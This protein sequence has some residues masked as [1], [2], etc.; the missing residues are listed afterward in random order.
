[1][2]LKCD[3]YLQVMVESKLVCAYQIGDVES[4]LNIFEQTTNASEPLIEIVIKEMLISDITKWI[5]KKSSALLNGGQNIK[6]CF[7]MLIF[8]GTKS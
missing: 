5:P 3:H 6:P 1:M 4:N 7:L 8:G 2:L